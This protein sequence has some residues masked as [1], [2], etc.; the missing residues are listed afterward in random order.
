MR[1]I[2]AVE[3]CN[4]TYTYISNGRLF[5]HA[6]QS[7]YQPKQLPI[8]RSIPTAHLRLCINT[9]RC[10]R[11]EKW[12]IFDDCDTI[13]S[14]KDVSVESWQRYGWIDWPSVHSYGSLTA[15]SAALERYLPHKILSKC[16]NA[17]S[18]KEYKLAMSP[19][20][21][22]IPLHPAEGFVAVGDVHL[23]SNTEIEVWRLAAA[24]TRPAFCLNRPLQAQRICACRSRRR[25]RIISSGLTSKLRLNGEG[26]GRVAFSLSELKCDEQMDCAP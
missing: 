26:A 6:H 17:M 14:I 23:F 10:G 12:R 7:Q 4:R 8:G 20:I 16:E 15:H 24:N 1:E 11:S 22:R 2:P 13:R 19:S 18:A 21:K 5:L 25:Q 9:Q 3:I